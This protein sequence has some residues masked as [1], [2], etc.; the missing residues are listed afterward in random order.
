MDTSESIVCKGQ[1]KSPRNVD[2]EIFTREKVLDCYR[3][4]FHK[5]ENTVVVDW[6]VC[7]NPTVG[8]ISKT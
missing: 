5:T 3:S 2:E 8:S 7:V 6:T 1:N 4:S